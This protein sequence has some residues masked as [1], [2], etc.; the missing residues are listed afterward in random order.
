MSREELAIDGGKPVRKDFLSYGRQWI[1][2]QDVRRVVDVL[3]GDWLTTGPTVAEFEKSFAAH[4]GAAE[5]VAVAN[6]TAALHLAMMA[7]DLK[8]L[9]EVLTTP[10][11]F[12]ATANSILYV[13]ARPVFV[14]V[15]PGTLNIDP[16]KIERAITPRTKGVAPVHFAGGPIRREEIYEI[17]RRRGLF[18]IEDA[19]HALGATYKGARIGAGALMTTFSF[20]PVKHITTGEGGMITAD[21]RKL[22]E[23]L[24]RLRNHGMNADARARFGPE[25]GWLY[26]I[27]ELGYNYRLTDIGCALGISQL[28]RLD[29][30]VERRRLIAGRYM[31]ELAGLPLSVLRESPGAESSWHLFPVLLDLAALG[32]GRGRV[33]AAL[34]AEGIGVNVHYMPVHYHPVYA[35]LGYRKGICPVAEA[36]YERLLSAPIFPMMTDEDQSDVIEAFRK[37]LGHYSKGAAR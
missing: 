3:K 19:A 23:R 14:D 22:A 15:E 26:E 17:A 11:T 32:V 18:V 28:A 24:R 34:R 25:G 37:V 7:A 13:G 8:E 6:G 29:E 10:M 1:D 9:D 16:S 30:F 2:D 4:S 36:A 27:D 20:H 21:D 5:A 33:F 31:E 35:R 12:A